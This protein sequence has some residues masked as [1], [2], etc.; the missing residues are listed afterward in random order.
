VGPSCPGPEGP[1]CFTSRRQNPTPPGPSPPNLS[2][3]QSYRPQNGKE[4]A[5][6]L[7]FTHPGIGG[8][9]L[10]NCQKRGTGLRLTFAGQ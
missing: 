4:Q 7:P 8:S 6:S 1:D 10:Q 3:G 2:H 5:Q 9:D